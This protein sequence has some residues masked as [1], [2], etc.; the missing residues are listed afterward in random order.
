[1]N[2][3][4]YFDKLIDFKII[5]PIWKIELDFI[6]EISNFNDKNEVLSLFS[7]YFSLVCDG[8]L[9]MSL[10]KDILNKKWNKKLI[11][12]KIRLQEKNNFDPKDIDEFINY[13]SSLINNYLKS[14]NDINLKDIIGKDKL[15]IIDNNYLYLRK[16]YNARTTII[17]ESNQIFNNT[18]QGKNIIKLDDYYKIDTDENG[19]KKVFKLTD[20]QKKV[21]EKGIN[22]NLLVTGGPGTGKTTSVLFLLACLLANDINKNIYITAPS[23]KAASRMKESIIKNLQT[24]IDSDKFKQNYSAVYDRLSKLEG[25]TI[26][27]LLGYKDGGF[28]YNYK[29]QFKDNSIFVI[30]EASMID[31]S[32]FS[33]L[34]SAIP[35][36]A[37]VF[38]LG[39]KDQLPSVEC[40]AVFGDLLK[41]NKFNNNIVMLDESQRFKKDSNI[42]NLAKAINEDNIP[43]PSISWE[44]YKD[45]NILPVIKDQYEIKYYKDFIEN[46][47]NKKNEEKIVEKIVDTWT[48]EFYCKL[49]NNSIG[50]KPND[51]NKL[52]NIFDN[53]E[54]SKILCAENES[55]RGVKNINKI[56]DK[57]CNPKKDGSVN[58]YHAGQILMVNSND[59]QLD[60]YNGD[61][62]IVVNFENDNMLYLMLKKT[63]NIIG[64][65]G[66]R[67]NKIFKIDNYVFYP[68]HMLPRDEIDLAYA[69]SVH[70]SQGSDYK[71]ILVFLPKDSEHPLLN[72]QIVYT[73]ITRTKGN[74]YIVSNQTNLEKA[75]NRILSRDTNIDI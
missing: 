43:L 36:K 15:F 72:R 50:L 16:Y 56:I 52:D 58:G 55:I 19:N 22:Y 1:M 13:S 6:D 31:A 38:I 30:D 60:L 57:K 14:I 54:E 59:Y 68:V 44:E 71:S 64:F 3:K 25:T 18:F 37:R 69:I 23:G 21:V 29:N 5:T 33:A 63:S 66:K 70:K 8:N 9:C 53:V 46:D 35:P 7:I 45:I 40:G 4:D 61:M 34:L 65:E 75:K 32:I 67:D 28:E 39:D 2:Y 49:K 11:E 62:G 51:K 24:G 17:R 41:V 74:T 27:R 42:Y 12:T 20:G 48:E 47:N 73:A 26:H 10:D